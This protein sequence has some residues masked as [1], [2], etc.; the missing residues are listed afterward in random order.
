MTSRKTV[1]PP[2][3]RASAKSRGD[4][5]TKE[6]RNACGLVGP[7]RLQIRSADGQEKDLSVDR[8]FALIGRGSSCEVTLPSLAPRQ[9]WLQFLEGRLYCTDL[10]S[11]TGLRIGGVAKAVGWL[12]PEDELE[13]GPYTI[14]LK[15][16]GVTPRRSGYESRQGGP[17]ALEFRGKQWSVPDGVTIL[18][19][20]STCTLR[21][22]DPGLDRYHCAVIRTG[23]QIWL[24]DLRSGKGTRVNGKVV[25]LARLRDGDLVQAGSWAGL[26]CV[27][28]EDSLD[29]LA[30]VAES[31]SVATLPIPY[32]Q[33]MEQFQQCIMMMGQMFSSMHQEHMAMVREH[34]AQLQNVA[35]E[36]PLGQSAVTDIPWATD[37]SP[38]PSS[39]PTPNAARNG[40]S[41]VLQDAHSW[42]T[43]RMATLGSKSPR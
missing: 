26:A 38:P 29:A 42:F 17:N 11:R 40:D 4:A 20:A 31:S 2:S 23:G 22:A 28:S 36:L 25:R 33:M 8:P 9:A 15:P 43:E 3:P 27:R 6:F 19:R 35:R 37:V 24:A 18:G 14:V 32:I 10:G 41:R 13:I 12:E 21:S 16:A 30:A 5:V 7:L 34:V 1:A 39:R